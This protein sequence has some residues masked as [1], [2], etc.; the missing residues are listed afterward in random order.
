MFT[1]PKTPQKRPFARQAGIVAIV[2]LLNSAAPMN[3]KAELDTFLT[4]PYLTTS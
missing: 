1:A 2:A 3:R 4:S